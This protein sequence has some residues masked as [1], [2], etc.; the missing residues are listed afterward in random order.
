MH[1]VIPSQVQ[2]LVFTLV[3]LMMFLSAHFTSLPKSHRMAAQP[4]GLS[5]PPSTCVI[6]RLSEG[7]L[8]TTSYIINGDVEQCPDIDLWGG[9]ILLASTQ[10]FV[11]LITTLWPGL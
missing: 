5:A 6:S 4:T 10:D 9:Q 7:A 11:P 3:K 1:V 2:D 8:C